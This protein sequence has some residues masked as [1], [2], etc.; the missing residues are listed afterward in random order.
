MKFM[1]R[2]SKNLDLFLQ[3]YALRDARRIALQTLR[4]EIPGVPL[5]FPVLALDLPSK[6]ES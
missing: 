1:E 6:C 4:L 3:L 2:F 5:S